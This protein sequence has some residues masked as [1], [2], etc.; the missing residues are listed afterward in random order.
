[1]A[2]NTVLNLGAGGDVIATDDIGGIKHELVKVEFGVDGVATQ[3]SAG[4]PLPVTVATLPLPAG[5]ATA[6]L[7]LPNGHDVTVD[8]AAG[9]A[10]VNVQDGGNSLTVDAPVGTPV[11]AR[12]S[13]GAAFLTTTGGRLAVDGSGVTQPV[14]AA[15][16]PL[17]AG[18]ATSALQLPAGHNVTALGAAAHDAPVSGNPVLVGLEARTTN[19]VA[20]ADGDAV[21]AMAD[22]LGRQVIVPHNTRDRVVDSLI[23]LAGTSETTL[24]AA[25]GAGIFADL[26]LLVI[27]NSSATP[28]SISFRSATG[29]SVRMVVT[30]A[31]RGG[32]VMPFPCPFKQTTANN[33]W[34]AQLSAVV[35][36]IDIFVQ[37]ATNV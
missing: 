1:M 37:A 35:S 15:S 27:T 34:T 22:D 33:N 12:L 17:P 29:G 31:A 26:T 25:Q 20:V 4:D 13:D 30:V 16:L 7:Q 8:N 3:V 14:S 23:N 24:L 32:I 6:A 19:P 11:A 5:A 36:S 18:A 10:A 28:V 2:D 9:G 21:R